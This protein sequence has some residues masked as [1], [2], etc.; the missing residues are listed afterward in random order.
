MLEELGFTVDQAF[1]L[2]ECYYPV[3]PKDNKGQTHMY[4]VR[5]DSYYVRKMLD[6]GWTHSQVL[7][8]LL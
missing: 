5:V 7:E 3:W 1:S 8:V 4:E 2:D 6:A